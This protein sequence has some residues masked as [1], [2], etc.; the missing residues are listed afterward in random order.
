[1]PAMNRL[2]ANKLPMQ[3]QSQKR[4]LFSFALFSDLADGFLLDY[5]EIGA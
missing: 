3:E 4:L 1:M 5:M 2:T